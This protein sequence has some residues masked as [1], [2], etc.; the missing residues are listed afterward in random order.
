MNDLISC[1]G[2]DCSACYCYG[3]MCEGCNACA[4]RSFMPLKK[5]NV[6]FILVAG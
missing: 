5:K 6:P 4:V 2:S 1:C 3:K